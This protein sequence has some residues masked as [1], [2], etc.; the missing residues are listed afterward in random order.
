[1][2]IPGRVARQVGAYQAGDV[3]RNRWVLGYGLFLLAVTEALFRFGA[4]G[5]QALLSLVDV[6]LGI[7]PLVTLVFGTL[8]VYR[9]REF[10]EV[11]LAQPVRRSSVFLGL[12]AGL[13][14]PLATLFVL[15]VGIPAVV[16]GTPES[17]GTLAVLLLV[18]VLLTLIFGGIALLI[19]TRAEDALRGLGA[20][21]AVWL[22]SAV[23]YDGLVLLAASVFADHAIERPLLAAMVANPVDLA[24][25]VLLL[26]F[27]IAA[28]LGYTG[29]I[30]RQFFGSAA[31]TGIALGALLV[32]TAG[33]ALLAMRAFRR[34]DF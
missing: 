6:V 14:V 24:R 17:A 1:M 10:V 33:P 18:G 22:L 2:N 9:S 27:D 5:D 4:D 30:F 25:V 13:T 21:V 31:G 3:L 28:L 7:V 8:Y 11:T 16:H 15:G 20:A 12:Y 26:H 32:W 23:L 34:K 19:A 29:A